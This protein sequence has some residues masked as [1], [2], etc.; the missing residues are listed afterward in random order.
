M[1]NET[2]DQQPA[3][4]AEILAAK[5]KKIRQRVLYGYCALMGAYIIG[6]VLGNGLD[7][8]ALI[9]RGIVMGVI[10]L[11]VYAVMLAFSK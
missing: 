11:V 2:S 10:C 9:A 6:G 3:D 8:G 7:I 1:N 4:T 5:K